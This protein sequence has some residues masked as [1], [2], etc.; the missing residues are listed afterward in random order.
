MDTVT[1]SEF[2][3]H[4]DRTEPVVTHLPETWDENLPALSG[5]NPELALGR[6]LTYEDTTDVCSGGS[7]IATASSGPGQSFSR[8]EPNQSQ[9]AR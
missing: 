1:Y 5:K 9:F 2:V 4:Q 3:G 7:R 6:E 8:T